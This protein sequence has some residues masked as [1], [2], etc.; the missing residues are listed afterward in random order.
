MPRGRPKTSS[1]IARE[2]SERWILE[3]LRHYPEGLRLTDIVKA[4]KGKVHKNTIIKRLAELKKTYTVSYNKELKRYQLT[5]V[6]HETIRKLEIM[7]IM[8]DSIQLVHIAYIGSEFCFSDTFIKGEKRPRPYEL[9]YYKMFE[10][11]GPEFPD[12]CIKD[13]LYLAKDE[14][15]IDAK[16]FEGKKSFDDLPNKVIDEMWRRL[17]KTP[18]KILYVEIVDTEKLLNF[19]KSSLGKV[20]MN[21]VITG[22]KAEERRYVDMYHDQLEKRFR[23]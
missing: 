20:R 23:R 11:K 16:F 15:L 7:D 8:R 1:K 5:D 17:F 21:Y 6:S 10:M 2:E 12:K 3:V 9:A 19:F 13:I 4:L 14:S 22:D 18:L